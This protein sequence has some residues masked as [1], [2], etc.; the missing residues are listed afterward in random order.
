[1]T[2]RTNNE[3]LQ[4]W[5][6]VEPTINRVGDRYF[7]Q[8]DQNGH[9]QRLSDLDEFARLGL[10]T[11][12]FP[13]LWEEIAPESLDDCHWTAIDAQLERLR[14]LGIRPIAGLLHHGS[15]PRYTSLVDP[16]FPEKLARFAAAVAERY[17]WIE[18]YTPVN[19]PL[20]TARF[21]GLYG[22]WYPHGRDQ[23]T[24][25]RCLMNQCRGVALAMRALREVNPAA[26]LVQ[27]DDLGKTYSTPRLS[28]QAEYENE[29]RWVTWD[30]LTGTL[31]R[32]GWMWRD[33]VDAGI[34]ERELAEFQEAPCPPGVIGINHYITSERFLDDNLSAHPPET[35]GGNGRE[36]YADVAAVRVRTEGIAG[37]EGVLREAWERYRL[38]LAVTEAHIGC[39]REEQLRWFMD[40]WR[41]A[42][43]LRSEGADVRAVTVWSLLGAHDWNSLLTRYEGFY[44]PGTYDLR[45]G[46]LRATA[47]AQMVHELARAGRFDHPTLDTPGWWRRSVRILPPPNAGD[48]AGVEPNECFPSMSLP[49]SRRRDRLAGRAILITGA[50]GRLAQGFIRAAELR[51]LSYRLFSR[52]DLDISDEA[53]VAHV[54]RETKPWAIV[55]CAGYSRVDDA[56][57]DEQNCI[58]TNTHG[59]AV[60]AR[61]GAGT[62]TRLVTFSSDQVFDGGRNEPYAESDEPSPLNVYGESKCLGEQQVLSACP[63]ALVI[64]PGKVFAPLGEDDFL[65]R[66]LRALARGERVRVAND[67]RISGTYL[68]DLVHATLDLLVDGERGIWHLANSG[69]VTPEQLLR[70]TAHIIGLAGDRIEG[71]AFWRLNRPALRPRNRALQSERG[72]L[73][74]PLEDALRR[75]GV[76]APAIYKEAAELAATS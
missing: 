12:R 23:R 16:E 28:F 55:N 40:V 20:T 59:A 27:T 17:P 52:A 50:N 32:D 26:E 15:G 74:P 19:E 8:L 46:A 9:R 10:R 1:M 68:P 41:G 56:E 72:Q 34:T 24:F 67:I 33:F 61:V 48:D 30:L 70:R 54:V 39:T 66:G 60:L 5:G 75:Y 53:A 65:R 6:G 4:V 57:A 25:L 58:R 47:I 51:G 36:Q 49:R 29:R 13:I 35:H 38:P 14:S 18:A 69:A 76:E 42:E 71:V 3:P 44:E 37:A 2:H 21:S 11:L 63:E 31:A 73:L 64:R 62:G 43:R 7:R 22:H 45:G